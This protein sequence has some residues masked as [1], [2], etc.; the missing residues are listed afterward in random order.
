MKKETQKASLALK[1]TIF[2]IVVLLLAAS[3][4]FSTKIEDFINFKYNKNALSTNIEVVTLKVHF[5]DVDQADA[6]LIE[7]PTGEKM[8]IDSG[9][10][11]TSSQTK[12]ENYLNNIDFKTEDGEKVLDYF[13]L[14]HSDADHIGGAVS[15]F[16]NYKVKTCVRPNIKSKSEYAINE[17]VAS[18]STDIYDNVIK[19]LNEEVSQSGCQSQTSTEGLVWKSKNYDES[20]L[21]NN[22]LIWKISFLTP[23]ASKLPYKSGSNFEYNNYS[24]LMMLEYMNKKIMFTGD[25]EKEVEADFIAYYSATLTNYDVDI[26]KVGHHGSKTSSTIEFLQVLKPEYAIIEVGNNNKYHHPDAEA[27]ENLKAVGLTENDIYRTDKNGNI[28]VGITGEGELRLVADYVQYI[29]FKFEWWE[30][31]STGTVLAAIIIF[32]PKKNYK[33]KRK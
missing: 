13:V 11:K 9:D 28:L 30:V 5:I 15:I 10:N 25:A 29:T 33:K 16:E 3:Y 2:L 8:L 22:N 23:I 24:P 21:N 4:F 32:V 17:D 14:T 18:T 31:F 6:I 12:L 7:F 1:F 26:L 20:L 27:I 19:A